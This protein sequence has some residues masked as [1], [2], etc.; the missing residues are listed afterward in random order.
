MRTTATAVFLVLS[1]LVS[2]CV[3]ANATPEATPAPVGEP[4]A[5]EIYLSPSG[6]R[7]SFE[8]LLARIRG[9]RVVY[10]GESHNSTWHHGFQLRVVEAMY[11]QDPK[12]LIGMEMFQRPYQPALDRFVGGETSEEQLL[13]ESEYMKRWK[14]DWRFYRGVL[15]FAKE[16]GIPVIALNSPAEVNRKVSRGGGLE[17]LTEED[18]PWVAEEVDLTIAEH[19]DFVAAVFAA[20]PMGPGFDFEAFYAS[21]CVWEDTMAESVARALDANPGSRMAVIVGRGHVQQRFGVPVRAERRG[22]KPYSIVAMQDLVPGRD[23]SPLAEY[24][25]ADLGDVLYFAPAAPRLGVFLDAKAE[26]EGLA[27]TRVMNGS[28]AELAGLEANDRITAINDAK[29]GDN[30]DLWNALSRTGRFGTITVLRDGKSIEY[31]FDLR[32]T[33]R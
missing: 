31:R 26:G 25:E 17:A 8:D 5:G 32:W 22:A 24:V 13:A 18:R 12:L 3:S 10:L 16:H 30:L 33:V 29:I 28:I 4:E 1:A 11:E 6:Q 23:V 15:L 14:W 20:H 7:V 27:V 21:Q 9:D 19:R 2:G